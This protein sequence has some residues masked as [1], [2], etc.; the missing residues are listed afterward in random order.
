CAAPGVVSRY[1]E[2]MR[3]LP[4]AVCLAVIGVLALALAGWGDAAGKSSGASPLTVVAA[5]TPPF[6]VPHYRTS[7]TYPQVRGGNADLKAV[8]AALRNAVLFHQREYAPYARKQKAKPYDRQIGV[9]RTDVDRRLLSASTVVVSALLP[10]TEEDFPGQHGGDGWLPMTVRVPSGEPVAITQLFTNPPQG[11]RAL[12]TAWK[13]IIRRTSAAPCLRAYHALYSSIP[14]YQD[15]ALTPHGIAVG[16]W[17]QE[18]CY[19]LLAIVPYRIMRPYL[20][21]LGATLVAGV[22]P[23]R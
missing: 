16:F 1:K 21:K 14:Q 12:A 5:R 17:E 20:S 22:R 11:L 7:G 18:V 23:A 19:R 4:H 15:F 2:T 6:P 13:A 3:R 9:Y 10:E 8:N